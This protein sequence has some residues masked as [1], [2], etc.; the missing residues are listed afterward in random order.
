[1]LRWAAVP[2]L[3]FVVAFGISLAHFTLDDDGGGKDAAHAARPPAAGGEGRLVVTYTPAV[4]DAGHGYLGSLR[5]DG[6]DLRNVIEPPGAGG[7]ASTGSPSVS[8][9]GRSARIPARRGRGAASPDRRSSTW[10]RSTARGPS[11]A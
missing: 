7:A 5:L 6:S 8:P 1:M 10:S 3:A 9:D 11:G 2:A 4:D